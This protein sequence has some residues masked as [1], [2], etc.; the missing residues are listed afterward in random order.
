MKYLIVVL[1]LINF[2]ALAESLS[3]QESIY[4][5][6]IDLNNDNQ[7]SL[8]EM[9]RALRLVFQLIDENNDEI[10]SK[11]EVLKLKNIIESLS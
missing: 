8:D 6:F 2:S 3:K 7:I 4:F 11:E 10:I 9:Y 1:F 5:N